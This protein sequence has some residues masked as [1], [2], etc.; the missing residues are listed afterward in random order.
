M[1]A[2]ELARKQDRINEPSAVAGAQV[3]H[4]VGAVGDRDGFNDVRPFEQLFIYGDFENTGRISRRDPGA[5]CLLF[6]PIDYEI[7]LL[8]R[9]LP[10]DPAEC[11]EHKQ[12]RWI[13]QFVSGGRE[14]KN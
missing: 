9:C 13:E 3:G 2:P 4:H 12:H 7:R 6:Q 1:V 14:H 8:P 10:C 5:A 11:R